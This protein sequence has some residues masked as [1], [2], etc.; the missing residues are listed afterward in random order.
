MVEDEAFKA[1]KSKNTKRNR[2]AVSAEVYGEFNRKEDFKPPVYP[3]SE[4]AI[5]RILILLNK[6]ILFKGLDDKDTKIVIDA[7]QDRLCK[8]GETII[9]EGEGGD[10]LFMVDEGEF[11]CHKKIDGVTTYLKTYK[12]GEAFGELAL[13]YNAPRAATIKAKTSGKL[14]ALDRNTFNNIVK[15]S[16]V[17]RKKLYEDTLKKVELLD[18][19]DP[20]E[21][22]QICDVLKEA[23][24]SPGEYVIR[25]GDSGDKFYIVV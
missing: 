24:Y 1:R 18:S 19:I 5:T 11:E 21:R 20:Y 3:K 16:T 13:L 6:S 9:E 2:S 15:E 4:E 8:P 25:Q 22:T 17:K 10:V 23:K 14:Y 12:I 7:M